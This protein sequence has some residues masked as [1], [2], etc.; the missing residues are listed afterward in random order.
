MERGSQRVGER[1]KLRMRDEVK[2]VREKEGSINSMW[3]ATHSQMET[4]RQGLEMKRE[5]VL[6][7]LRKRDMD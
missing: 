4:G 7:V 3:K 6:G 5:K 2:S 1:G